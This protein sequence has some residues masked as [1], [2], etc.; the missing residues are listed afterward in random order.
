MLRKM[1]EAEFQDESEDEDEDEEDEEE[2]TKKT[3]EKKKEEA[4][5]ENEKEKKKDEKIEKE[6]ES[7]AAKEEEEEK[8]E[9]EQRKKE[10]KDKYREFWKEFGKNIKLGIIEDSSNRP[11]LA[12]ITRWFSS[13]NQT[14]LITFDE[15]LERAKSGQ[16]TIYFLAGESKDTIMKHPTLQKL[17]KKGYEVLLLDDP[18][19][20][21]TFQHLT[22][23]EKKK[24]VNVGKGDFKFPDEDNNERKRF[25]KLKKMFKPLTEWW[26]KILPNDLE[27]VIISQRLV[28][29]PCVLVSS[30]YGY[31]ANMERI[32]KAQAYSS[33][34]KSN[35]YSSGKKILE[36]NPSHPAIKELFERVKED[37]DQETEEL[38]NV[39]YE[40]A[41]I[42]S[43]YGVKDPNGFAKRFYRLY[44]GALGIAKDAPVKEIEIDL[45]EEEADDEDDKEKAKKKGLD[46]QDLDDDDDTELKRSKIKRPE[47]TPE[48]KNEQEQNKE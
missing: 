38:A 35:P 3:D 45:S 26:K 23:Y 48:T 8:A 37:P 11:K 4:E 24:L 21:F 15:Y 20:E 5:N 7:D 42:N 25:K 30:E 47:E 1:S 27:N 9:A 31:S 14:E 6:E 22:E 32:S 43:G 34:D 19:D 41:A 18:I 29:D 44:N 16:D 39:L 33:G 28:D 2:T 46:E 40:G 12:K 10:K 17:L 36:I 13:H